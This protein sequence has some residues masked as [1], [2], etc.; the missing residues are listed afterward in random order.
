LNGGDPRGDLYVQT[1]RPTQRPSAVALSRLPLDARRVIEAAYSTVEITDSIAQR[2]A[3]QVAQVRRYGGR[4]QSVVQL[5]ENDILSPIASFHQLTA[6]LDKIAA[7]ELVG[8]R[9]DT[10]SNQLLSHALEQLLAQA[11]RRRDTEVATMNMRIVSM[12]RG[13]DIARSY[14]EGSANALR[15]WRQP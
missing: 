7:G 5:L 2:G 14:I 8:R 3:H 9:Q 15:N 6:V 4:L 12:Q 10:A 11:K 13:R 1:A